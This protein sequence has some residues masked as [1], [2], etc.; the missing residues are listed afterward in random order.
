MKFCHLS[1]ISRILV[2]GFFLTF[3]VRA[4]PQESGLAEMRIAKQHAAAAADARALEQVKAELQQALNC[5]VGRGDREFR[6]NVGDP[7]NGHE[8]F[9]NSIGP[10]RT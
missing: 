9:F 10:K 8:P 6:P 1:G 7:C 5:L 3:P 2:G 4:L